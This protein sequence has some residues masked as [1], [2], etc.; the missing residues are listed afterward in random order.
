MSIKK[1]VPVL[2]DTVVKNHTSHDLG[3]LPYYA[4]PANDRFFDDCALFHSS[5]LPD[6]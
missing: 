2:D 1:P 3:H 4:M 5:G 6:A